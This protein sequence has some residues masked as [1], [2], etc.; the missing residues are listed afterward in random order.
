MAASGELSAHVGSLVPNLQTR[1]QQLEEELKEIEKQIFDFEESYIEETNHYGN[2]IRGW[3][4][5]VNSK[6]KALE[7]GAR[8]PKISQKDRVFS[9]SSVSAPADKPEDSDAAE[10]DDEGGPTATAGYRPRRQPSTTL[11]DD[12]EFAV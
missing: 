11:D 10:G 9:L 7:A 5:F 1:K 2:V 12:D 6:P 4:G 3:E 8:K